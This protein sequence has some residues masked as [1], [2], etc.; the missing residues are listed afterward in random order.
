LQLRGMRSLRMAATLSRK[1]QVKR[2]YVHRSIV[3]NYTFHY[4]DNVTQWEQKLLIRIRYG[5]LSAFR[6]LLE[7]WRIWKSKKILYSSWFRQVSVDSIFPQY[8][9]N[10]L[11]YSSASSIKISANRTLL[12]LHAYEKIIYSVSVFTVK[13]YCGIHIVIKN[14][15]AKILVW[16]IR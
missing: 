14:R 5:S 11:P 2:I 12:K 3:D 10:A 6:M 13:A 16:C 7:L 8:I 15:Y 1:L 4:H 9:S